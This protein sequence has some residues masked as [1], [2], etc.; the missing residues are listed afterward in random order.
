MALFPAMLGDYVTYA[1]HIEALRQAE[2]RGR[3]QA[4]DLGLASIPDIAV[5]GQEQY[6]Q[7][8]RDALAGAVEIAMTH[9]CVDDDCNCC[10]VIA[11]AIKGDSDEVPQRA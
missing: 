6:E 9:A 11:T 1:D 3:E 8:Q 4:L 5:Y 10:L 2:Q 7:G